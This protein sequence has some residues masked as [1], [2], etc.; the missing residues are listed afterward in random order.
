MRKRCDVI[1]G[2]PTGWFEA[3]EDDRSQLWERPIVRLPSVPTWRGLRITSWHARLGDESRELRIPWL[4]LAVRTDITS[5]LVLSNEGVVAVCD[6]AVIVCE[7]EKSR[8][9][10]LSLKLHARAH[11]NAM[12]NGTLNLLDHPVVQR[13]PHGGL[14][15]ISTMVG[16]VVAGLCIANHTWWRALLV[17]VTFSVFGAALE[18]LDVKVTRRKLQQPPSPSR[19]TSNGLVTPDG[20]VLPWKGP[21][22]RNQGQSRAGL[23]PVLQ[24][25]VDTAATAKRKQ[26]DKAFLYLISLSFSICAGILYG[27]LYGL[28]LRYP[29]EY[30]APPELTDELMPIALGGSVLTSSLF[31]A[32]FHHQRWSRNFR[33]WWRRRRSAKQAE[34]VRR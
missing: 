25:A 34:A 1:Q 8:Y 4:M 21:K 12:R 15:V 20:R 30:V 23:I 2:V 28:E 31:T 26:H 16:L 13:P 18:F 33:R 7:L 17:L 3:G 29:S 14:I 11:I 22:V 6:G 9:R 27:A 5:Y 10:H 32:Y 19:Y 24:D